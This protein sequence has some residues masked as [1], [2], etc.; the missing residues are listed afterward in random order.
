MFAPVRVSVV[1]A[2]ALV[3]PPVL[4]TTPSNCASFAKVKMRTDVPKSAFPLKVS[5]PVLV[6]LPKVT[7]PPKVTAFKKVR[8][9]VLL[10]EIVPPLR[11]RVPVPTALLAI[12]PTDPTLSTPICKT[13]ALR[14]VVPV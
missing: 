4:L 5:L 12:A 3:R 11:A 13:P 2:P 7:P 1:P 8:G 14:V 10:E 6:A 9:V